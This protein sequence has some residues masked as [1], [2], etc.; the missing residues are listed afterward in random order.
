M[1]HTFGILEHMP[2]PVSFAMLTAEAFFLCTP[3]PGVT[4]CLPWAPSIRRPLGK[5]GNYFQ[6]S[7]KY[8]NACL[9]LLTKLQKRTWKNSKDNVCSAVLSHITTH[10]CELRQEAFFSYCIPPSRA[11]LLQHVKHAASHAVYVSAQALEANPTLPSHSEWGW[12]LD[13]ERIWVPLLSTLPEASKGCRD[14]CM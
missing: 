10:S 6:K 11:A 13:S 2:L 14:V 7:L 5:Y 8:F 1:V 3:Y 12:K 9:L 4:R